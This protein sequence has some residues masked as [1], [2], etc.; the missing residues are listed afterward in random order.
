MTS[1]SQ[2][3][4]F[5]SVPLEIS[6]TDYVI[7]I[8]VVL[9]SELTPAQSRNYWEKLFEA[10]EVDGD[11]EKKALMKAIMVY[12]VL[13]GSSNRAPFRQDIFWSNRSGKASI[14][15]DIV[16]LDLR[17]FAR[18]NDQFA[19]SIIMSDPMVTDAVCRKFGCRAQ[20]AYYV[21]DFAN[22]SEAPADMRDDLRER[23]INRI[24]SAGPYRGD[25]PQDEI[26]ASAAFDIEETRKPVVNLPFT[27][28]RS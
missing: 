12:L 6:P 2:K 20:Y 25:R 19:R 28:R 8:P 1:T 14:I 7:E 23:A 26:N 21:Y 22:W 13:N 3:D 9:E 16:G 27:A 10:Y 5:P 15:N 11:H 17:R 18:A 24:G 4:K